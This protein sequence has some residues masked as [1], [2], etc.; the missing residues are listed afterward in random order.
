MKIVIRVVV[1][2]SLVILVTSNLYGDHCTSNSNCVETE[3]LQCVDEMCDCVP[4]HTLNRHR[5]CSL[6]YGGTCRQVLDCN[7]DA[8]L[9]CNN[10]L[11]T[12]DCQQPDRQIWDE[13]RDACVSLIGYSC[14]HDNSVPFAL[15][16]VEGGYCDMPIINGS[17]YH[18]CECGSE[19]VE[20]TDKRCQRRSTQPPSISRPN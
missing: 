14:S 8:F 15:F 10:T 16:C 19:W 1:I 9:K 4:G 7:I 5:T 17:M 12:C 2:T 18:S 11:L 3:N 20:T 13:Q 6:T